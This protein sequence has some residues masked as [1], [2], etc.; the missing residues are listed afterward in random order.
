ML[1]L[2]RVGGNRAVDDLLRSETDGL[3]AVVEEVVKGGGGKPLDPTT[4]VL[5]ESRMN[6]DL[7]TV[8]IHT[9]SQAAGSARE[10][11]ARAYVVN[12]DIVFGVGEFSPHTQAGKNLL[13]H[14][15]VH[16]LQ[17]AVSTHGLAGLSDS[18]RGASM[19]Q[20][21]KPKASRQNRRRGIESSVFLCSLQRLLRKSRQ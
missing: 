7:S 8:R 10:M 12:Q 13:T 6:Q 14:E 18:D 3:P 21:D 15:L 11:K 4:R 1:A 9:D 20:S 5:M 17:N 16:T 2:Q 19:P